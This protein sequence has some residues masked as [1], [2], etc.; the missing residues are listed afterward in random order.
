MKR[1]RRR[2]DWDQ[3]TVLGLQMLKASKAEGWLHI[4]D[5]EVLL[6]L[7]DSVACPARLLERRPVLRLRL[8]CPPAP[9]LRRTTQP[10]SEKFCPAP[11]SDLSGPFRVGRDF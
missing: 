6:R 5:A 11:I 7:A 4:F 2:K 3:A 10:R 8:A 1:T 9:G